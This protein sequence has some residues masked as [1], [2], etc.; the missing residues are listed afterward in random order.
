MRH[1]NF[2]VLVIA[3]SLVSIGAR[4][5]DRSEDLQERLTP[6][7]MHDT[8][9]DT[10]SPP[11]LELLNR[12][13]RDTSTPAA[14]IAGEPDAPPIN[15]SAPS[16]I[17]ASTADNADPDIEPELAP[18]LDA[19][20]KSIARHV[21]GDVQSWAPG[22]V[23]ELDNGHRWKVLKGA[24]T[25]RRKLHEPEVFL[26]PGVFGRWFLQVTEDMPKARVYRVR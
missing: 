10:L 18:Y 5:D 6:Q 16:P 11:Q 17:F 14:T 4:A 3:L 8:G 23:F 24:V 22:T 7:Q 13:L 19:S 1:F 2:A 15:T 21:R 9:L 26:V 20:G 25:L 12:L